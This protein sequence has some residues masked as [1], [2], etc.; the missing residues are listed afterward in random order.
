ML[1]ATSCFAATS[2]FA[3]APF[4]PFA[5]TTR[6]ELPLDA[7]HKFLQFTLRAGRVFLPTCFA[8]FGQLPAKLLE[9][10]ACFFRQLTA[11]FS[12]AAFSLFAVSTLAT[13]SFQ[14]LSQLVELPQPFSRGVAFT[15]LTQF[16]HLSF[17]FFKLSTN[18]HRLALSLL[19]FGALAFTAFP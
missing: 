15:S 4:C 14:T 2:L 1:Q 8:M 9:S 12:F 13:Q 3:F 5:F 16:T 7:G 17:E 18:F 11:R 19:S 6:T 10:P